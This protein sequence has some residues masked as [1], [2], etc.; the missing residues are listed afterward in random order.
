VPDR[1]RHRGP[2]P[3]DRE[4]FGAG[5]VAALQSATTDLSWL[6]GRGYALPSSLAL[7]GNRYALT[8]RQRLAVSRCA[9]SDEAVRKRRERECAPERIAGQR[10]WIDGYNLLTSVETAMSGAVLLHA[11]DGCYRDVASVHGSY[12]CVEETLPAILA[13][14]LELAAMR[15]AACRWLLDRPVSNSG[16]LKTLLLEAAG[17]HGWPWQVD[18]VYGPDAEL[19]ASEAIVV[20]ADRVVLDRCRGWLNLARRTINARVPGAWVVDLSG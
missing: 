1:R 12:R 14:G 11:R 9:A 7:V 8:K 18:V 4:R 19:A 16:R 6:E 2:H 3:G 20:T 15:P 13:I 10:V 5:A 17:S